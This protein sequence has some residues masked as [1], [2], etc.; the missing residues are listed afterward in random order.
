MQMKK[1]AC[2]LFITLI[3]LQS[4]L[5]QH[6]K[7]KAHIPNLSNEE[8]NKVAYF[9][10]GCF[11]CVEAIFESVNGVT[12]VISGYAGGTAE[13]A[14][15]AKVSSGVTNHAESVAVFYDST[16]VEY[17]T[18]LLVFFDSHDPSTLN[19]QGPDVGRQYRSAIFYSSQHE[20]ILAQ[21]YIDDL[22]KNKL[23]DSITTEIIPF[24]A[25]YEAETYH[26]D[27]K[28]NHPDDPYV[29]R[30]SNPRY[31]SFAKKH[32]KLLKKH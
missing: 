20:K 22:L 2:G 4:C 18:L 15:Y 21:K 26:Q 24:E 3:G 1:I 5:T 23:F 13:D 7:E 19:R 16:I 31:D 30:I 25:F 28:K 32:K 10:S 17:Q 29:Q 14:S 9:A 8:S 12:E 6:S 27:Y 11:W